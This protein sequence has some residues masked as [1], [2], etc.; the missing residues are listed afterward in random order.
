MWFRVNPQSSVPIYQQVIQGIRQ[1]V[2]QGVVQAGDRLPSVR[3]L[4]VEMTL[5]PN[6]IAKAYRE[7]ERQRVI[8]V[9]QGR[10]TYIADLESVPDRAQRIGLM[11]EAIQQLLVRRTIC[12]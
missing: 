6:T 8:T 4:A 12:R 1:G 3:D 10:G 2:A 11:V 7:L 5:N 9:I